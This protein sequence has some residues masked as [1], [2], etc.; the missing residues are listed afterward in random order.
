MR[1][2][3]QRLHCLVLTATQT[4]RAA[5]DVRV[6]RREHV[7]GDHRKL[8]EVTGMVGI[9]QS[10]EEKDLGLYRLNWV[11]QRSLDFSED[12]C[13]WTASCLAVNDPCIHSSF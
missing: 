6:L 2:L 7:G 8:A 9:N 4:N 11:V 10:A 5:F 3:S 1:S 12:R 13:L